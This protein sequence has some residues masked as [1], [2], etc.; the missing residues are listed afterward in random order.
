MKRSGSIAK[1]SAPNILLG[2][3]R[4]S[5]DPAVRILLALGANA[6]KFRNET[7]RIVSGPK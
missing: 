7:I 1:K 3:V 2:L 6:D 5:D 4:E